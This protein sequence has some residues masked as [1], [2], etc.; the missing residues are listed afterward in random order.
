M[1]TKKLFTFPSGLKFDKGEDSLIDSL[2]NST[3]TNDGWYKVTGRKYKT[4]RFFTGDGKPLFYIVKNKY[5]ITCGNLTSN[6]RKFYHMDGTCT[7]TNKKLGFDKLGYNAQQT[8][9]TDIIN[10]F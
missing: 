2:F 9:I 10:A 1:N 5:G 4:I 7:L 8:L 3:S 6:N